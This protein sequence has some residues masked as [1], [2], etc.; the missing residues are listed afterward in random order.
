MRTLTDPDEEEPEPVDERLVEKPLDP[1]RDRGEIALKEEAQSIQHLLTHTPKNPF[2]QACSRAKMTK[3]PSYSKGGS[4]QVEADQ[5]GQHLTA[6]HLV[7][8]D[9]EEMDIDG[10][11]VALVVKDVA[12]NFRYVYPAARRSTRECIAIPPSNE[13]LT[14]GRLS[15]PKSMH[16]SSVALLTYVSERT[17][18]PLLWCAI[19]AP[20]AMVCPRSTPGRC[21]KLPRS[22]RSW[23]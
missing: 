2:C 7:I 17:W 13:Q 10:A 23:E 11:R 4:T 19:A 8:R 6:D 15:W 16:N 12:T 5:F 9:D 3:R 14:N 18:Q 22:S 21:V 20:R 1:K